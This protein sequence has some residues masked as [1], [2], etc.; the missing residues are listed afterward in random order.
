MIL[1]KIIYQSETT[2]KYNEK[3]VIL[4]LKLFISFINKIKF[5]FNFKLYKKEMHVF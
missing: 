3:K 1:L 2:T 5:D 4:C